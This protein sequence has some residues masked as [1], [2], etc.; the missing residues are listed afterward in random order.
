M[1]NLL[2]SYLG[3][4][5][6]IL[7]SFGYFGVF[8][9]SLLDRLTVFLIPAEVVL[10]AFGILIG[11]GEFSFWP[12]FIW[13]TVGNFLGNLALYAIFL[14][15]GRPFLEKYGKYLLISHHDLQHLDAMF[16]KYG[17]KLLLF[18]YLIPTAVRSLVPIPAGIAR[19]SLKKFSFY[20]LIGSVPLNILYI[21]IGMKAEDNLA[22]IIE[23]F[24]PI[25]YAVIGA[26]VAV[27]VLYIYRHKRRKH[28]THE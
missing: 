26:L 4:I 28:L 18:G 3:K 27:A 17:D 25:N 9:L 15:G 14:K 11:Q 24:G 16:K 12:V 22:N 10:P 13:A 2:A 5:I 19:V 21:I 23:Y 6:G 1:Y 20:T 8:S 7:N